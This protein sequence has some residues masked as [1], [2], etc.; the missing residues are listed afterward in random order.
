MSS[1]TLSNFFMSLVKKKVSSIILLQIVLK[2]LCQL[3]HKDA[4]DEELEG[5]I[6]IG[7][8][9]II[10]RCHHSTFLSLW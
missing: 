9:V 2:W 3:R 4:M 10:M 8:Q 1:P 7:S 6:I 5:E